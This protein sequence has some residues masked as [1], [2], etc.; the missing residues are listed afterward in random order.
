MKLIVME[1][2]VFAWKTTT[3]E[4]IGPTKVCF[5]HQD[6]RFSFIIFKTTQTLVESFMNYIYQTTPN[7]PYPMGRSGSISAGLGTSLAGLL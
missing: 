7:A 3:T 2:L 4:F 5:G 1:K 6:C